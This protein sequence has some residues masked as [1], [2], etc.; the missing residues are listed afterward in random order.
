MIDTVRDRWWRWRHRHCIPVMQTRPEY[1]T[2]AQI[3]RV[4]HRKCREQIAV[5]NDIDRARWD[6]R[7]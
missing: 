4:P 2:P 3:A 1:R 5:E 7:G 6:R